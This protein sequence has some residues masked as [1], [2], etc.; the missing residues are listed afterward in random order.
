MNRCSLLLVVDV[1]CLLACLCLSIAMAEQ[2]GRYRLRPVGTVE[3]W[4]KKPCLD[5]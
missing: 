3:T 5:F 4:G 2:P 1:G